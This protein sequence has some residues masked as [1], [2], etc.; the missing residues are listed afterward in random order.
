[1]KIQLKIFLPH[2]SLKQYFTLYNDQDAAN[3]W[4]LMRT[5]D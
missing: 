5:T 1:M 3:H 2:F 4:R